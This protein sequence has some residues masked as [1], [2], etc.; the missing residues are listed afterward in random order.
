MMLDKVLLM[1]DKKLTMP[2]YVLFMTDEKLMMPDEVLFMTD[3]IMP[4]ILLL[5]GVYLAA[6]KHH[7]G[8]FYTTSSYFQ[9]TVKKLGGNPACLKTVYLSCFRHAVWIYPYIYD[10]LDQLI[11]LQL[12]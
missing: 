8:Q 4:E 7:A 11:S 3:K 1:T 5:T 10:L 2:D 6:R 9:V 12:N